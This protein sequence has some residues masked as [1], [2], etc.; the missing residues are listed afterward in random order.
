MGFTFDDTDRKGVATP[1]SEMN[2]ILETENDPPYA[3]RVFPY[4]GGEEVNDS[5]TQTHHR[6]VINF[7]MMNEEEAHRWPLLMRILEAKVRGKRASHSTA[8]WWHLERLR[9]E[10][11]QAIRCLSQVLVISRVGQQAAFVYLPAR[12][13]YSEQLVV[14]ALPTHS[15]ICTLQCRVHEIWARFFGSTLEDR[16]RYT[17]SD[18]FETFPFPPAFETDPRLESAGKAYY[19]F[20]A[21][22]MIENNEGLTK[23]YNRFHDPNEKSP[24]IQ[25]LQEL[26]AAMD[27]AVL[28]A[29][30][31]TDF[32]P[33]CEFLLDY[34][35][36]E[37]EE[38]EGKARRRK[39]PY[40]YR[41]VDEDRDW[42]L[43]KLLEL[44]Q[45]RAEEER[46]RG[47]A[48]PPP[49]DNAVDQ[50]DE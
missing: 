35:E 39:K 28:D 24:K 19:E 33:R 27:R 41:W 14:F 34:E 12:M 10:L 20:R 9:E 16:L 13:V 21:N 43:A 44:N 4:I 8:E 48:P 1:L 32:T 46:L 5:P 40:R 11:Y 47:H 42:V 45:Q 23:T 18:C 50:E 31:W 7:G 2:R 29:Y 26:H 30:G 22:L 15:A 6:Y 3:E 38:D 17:P 49:E 25:R 36:E 37:N